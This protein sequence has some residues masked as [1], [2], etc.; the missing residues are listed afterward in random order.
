MILL[1]GPYTGLGPYRDLCGPGGKIHAGIFLQDFPGRKN[2]CW[3]IPLGLRM[4]GH[5]LRW[6]ERW[7]RQAEWAHCHLVLYS[8]SDAV[9]AGTGIDLLSNSSA[10]RLATVGEDL[11]PERT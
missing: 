7:P 11:T 4:P 2:P 8:G 6:P 9:L 3:N 10:R 1:I 5:C